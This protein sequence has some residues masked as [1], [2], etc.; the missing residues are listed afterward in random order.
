[1]GGHRIT[2]NISGNPEEEFKKLIKEML[3]KDQY[4]IKDIAKIFKKKTHT[5]RSWERKGIIEKPNKEGQYKWR[6]YTRYE[7]CSV[8]EDVLDYEWERE[9]FFNAGQIQSLI[10]ILRENGGWKK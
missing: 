6:Y 5:I 9:T 10:S 2:S 7:F 8:L 4:N 3:S 1:M